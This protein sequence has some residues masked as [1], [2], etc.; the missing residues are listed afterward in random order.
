[1]GKLDPEK[2]DKKK[3]YEVRLFCDLLNDEMK[4]SFSKTVK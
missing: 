4:K 2:Q 1:L 3:E